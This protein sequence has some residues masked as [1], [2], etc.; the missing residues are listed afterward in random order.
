MAVMATMEMVEMEMVEMRIQM[1]MV[2]RFQEHTMMCTKMVPEEEDRV[3]K[4]IG[5]LPDNIQGNVVA[6]EPMRLQDGLSNYQQTLKDQNVEA[7]LD[8]ISVVA[9]TYS[10]NFRRP[11]P[12]S[13]L[14]VLSVV[15][16]D[17]TEDYPKAKNQNR[18]RNKVKSTH[19]LRRGKANVRTRKVRRKPGFQHC[20][21]RRVRSYLKTDHHAYMLFDSSADRSFVSNTFSTLLD[22]TPYALYVSYAV[23]LAGGRTSETNTVL[24]GCTLALT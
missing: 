2:E 9:D 5:G 18:G 20:P 22:I 12:W 10:R 6:A 14:R 23:E 13:L 17:L 19:R 15:H 11:N 3:E 8:I 7:M 21:P 24:R 16:K 1:R 4:F